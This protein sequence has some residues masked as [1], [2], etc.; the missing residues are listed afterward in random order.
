MSEVVK[1]SL[2]Y[3]L[4][5]GLMRFFRSKTAL[6]LYSAVEGLYRF[7][8]LYQ[9]FEGGSDIAGKKPFYKYSLAYTLASRLWIRLDAS[10][11]RLNIFL[12]EKGSFSVTGKLAGCIKKAYSGKWYISAA[13]FAFGISA[14]LISTAM[15]AGGLNVEALLASA[16]FLTAGAVLLLV[17]DSWK[18]LIEGS[19]VLKLYKY[20]ME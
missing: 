13:V 2:L 10:F 16:V 20:F 17:R 3:S 1:G 7:S 12:H 6:R 11:T 4:Y 5:K 9:I 19:M 14:G 8:L 18:Q 15:A